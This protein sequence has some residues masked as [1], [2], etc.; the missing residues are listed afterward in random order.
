M[1]EDTQHEVRPCTANPVKQDHRRI[2]HRYYPTLGFGE[3][4][5]A[6][7][8]CRTVDEVGDF[9]RQRLHRAE[10]V[11]LADHRERFPKSVEELKALF[12]TA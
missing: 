1:G 9:L 8:F 6:Q 12:Q 4:H 3:F 10:F 2:K 5:A 7:R 11:S